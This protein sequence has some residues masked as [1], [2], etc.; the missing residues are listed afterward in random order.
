MD[1]GVHWETKHGMPELQEEENQGGPIASMPILAP[2]PPMSQPC[3]SDRVQQALISFEQCDETRPACSACT[4][5]KLTC[6]GY[7]RPLDLILRDQN[8]IA[9]DKVHGRKYRKTT[10]SSSSKSSSTT[11]PE[12]SSN[13]QVI[14][15][16]AHAWRSISLPNELVFNSPEYA[17]TCVFFSNVVVI[18]QHPDTRRGFIQAL[19]PLY[20]AARPG[21]LL[22]LAVTTVSLAM[23]GMSRRAQ[24]FVQLGHKSFSKALLATARAIEDPTD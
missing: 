23:F 22:D 6:P 9:R 14:P 15:T 13:A 12:P 17:A 4:K 21:S 1:H 11:S 19:L 18:N 8:K 5:T 7:R 24:E 3:T 2:W 16:T 10:S 20:N